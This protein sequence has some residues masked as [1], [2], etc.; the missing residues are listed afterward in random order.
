MITE[1]EEKF[2][3][4]WEKNRIREKSLARQLSLIIPIGSILAIGILLNFIT[5]WYTRANIE[6]NSTST[7]PVII[8]AVVII[9][10][11]CSV[12]FKRHQW[13]MN[14]QRYLELKYKKDLNKSSGHMQQDEAN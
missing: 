8:V 6:A 9:A 5:G 4:Y 3:I 1:E 13:E 7:M 11:F 12:F 10:I 2:L 14:D